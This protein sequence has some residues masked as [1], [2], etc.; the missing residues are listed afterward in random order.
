MTA[1]LLLATLTAQ[2]PSP[3]GACRRHLMQV[4]RLRQLYAG[5]AGMRLQVPTVPDGVEG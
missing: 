3:S 5:G 2:D 4:D 1:A